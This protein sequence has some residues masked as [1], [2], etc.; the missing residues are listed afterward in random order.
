MPGG[1]HRFPV[2]LATQIGDMRTSLVLL[3]LAFC[4]GASAQS[5]DG[6]RI[7]AIDRPP[8]LADFAGMD[9]S[10][11][12]RASMTLISDFVQRLPDDGDPATERTDVYLGYDDR[13]LYAVFLAF[14]SRPE[15]IRANLS[16]RE[17]IDNDDTVGLMIDT[18]NDQRAAYAF[19]ST[20]LGVQWDARWNEVAR[21]PAFDAAYQAVWYTDGRVTD[22]GYMVL[23]TI[24][25]RTLRFAEGVEQVWRIMLERKIPRR[26]EEAY[27]PEYS[28]AI[29]GRLNQAAPLV[30][31]RDVSPGRNIQV[32]PFVFARDFDVLDPDAGAGPTFRNDR[33]DDVGLDAKFVFQDSMVLDVTLNPTSA[34]LSPT[35]R[36]SPSTSASR[37]GFRSCGRSSSRTPTTSARKRSSCSRAASSIPKQAPGSPEGWGTGASGRCS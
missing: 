3:G 13:N 27:W 31:V 28:I 25:M 37:C 36:R 24:P 20:P 35:S 12:I 9:P 23:M 30:G 19:R 18:F 2:A 32:V 14:D 4:A 7:P 15:L 33:E 22:S 6:L 5:I 11:E 34:R 21:T 29:E 10:T 26:S 17:N 16:P 8:T 1:L